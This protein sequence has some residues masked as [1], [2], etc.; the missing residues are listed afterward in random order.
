MNIDP[1][2]TLGV[3]HDSTPADWKRAYRRLAMRWHPDRSDD[4]QA[5]ERFKEINAAYEQLLAADQPD[6]V[7]EDSRAG[8]T[9]RMSR[10]SLSP[11]QRIFG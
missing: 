5:T 10:N 8:E 1:F 11:R 6:V 2:L 9:R 4:P 7:D 3:A